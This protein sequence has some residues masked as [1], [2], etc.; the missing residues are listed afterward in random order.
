MTK[1]RIIK[2]TME[3][4]S[5]KW[6]LQERRLLVWFMCEGESGQHYFNTR[7]EVTD[8]YWKLRSE[9]IWKEEV[10]RKI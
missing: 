2:T 1:F 8:L 3:D 6:S 5:E 9:R 10:V 7:A 4:C